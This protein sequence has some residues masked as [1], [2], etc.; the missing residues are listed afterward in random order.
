MTRVLLLIFCFISLFNASSQKVIG[1]H[2]QLNRL[3]EAY[4]FYYPK[5]WFQGAGKEIAKK[6]S[7]P[8]ELLSFSR[9]DTLLNTLVIPDT[10]VYHSLC[11]FSTDERV[12]LKINDPKGNVL[13]V[14]LYNDDNDLFGVFK[15][16]DDNVNITFDSTNLKLNGSQPISHNVICIV[17]SY[18]RLSGEVQFTG[19]SDFD[20]FE[21][22]F[23]HPRELNSA[24][25]ISFFEAANHIN[26]NPKSYSK[27]VQRKM[28]WWKGLGVGY[29]ADFDTS[30]LAKLANENLN[31]VPYFARQKAKINRAYYAM[32]LGGFY[33]P[34]GDVGFFREDFYFKFHALI[35]RY[36]TSFDKTNEV[37][38]A[39][40]EKPIMSRVVVGGYKSG[41][42][43]I[44]VSI[45]NARHELLYNNVVTFSSNNENITYLDDKLY[46]DVAVEEAKYVVVRLYGLNYE[47]SIFS[48]DYE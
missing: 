25:M 15:K 41:A 27:D 1:M 37:Y 5:L 34:R 3:A 29:Q 26:I 19:A 32:D 46:I 47:R 28:K 23:I 17:R 8:N 40:I 22:V 10:G 9:R 35:N 39:E 45:V 43:L 31:W 30:N 4:M 12:G 24:Q 6:Q 11:A 20:A 16:D 36:Y 18:S 2:N 7:N 48:L 42:D 13:S 33:I 14:M 38:I 44:T 21:N